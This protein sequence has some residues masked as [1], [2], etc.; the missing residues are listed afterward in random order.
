MKKNL[1]SRR[2]RLRK[3]RDGETDRLGDAV[4]RPKLCT[5]SPSRYPGQIHAHE[6]EE[7]KIVLFIEPG[8]LEVPERQTDP[9]A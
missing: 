6:R 9:A 2:K 7:F 1:F 3:T 8:T 5:G 4:A